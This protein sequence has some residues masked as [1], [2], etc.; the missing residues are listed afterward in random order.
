VNTQRNIILIFIFLTTLVFIGKLYYIQVVDVSFKLS[1]E[2]N[3]FRHITQYPARGIIFD[4][5]NEVIVSNEPTYDLKVYPD[6]LSPFDTAR[7]SELTNISK[8]ELK[9][10]LKSGSRFEAVTLIKQMPKQQYARLQEFLYRYP[11]FYTEQRALR[12]YRRPIA[13]HILGYVSE[14]KQSEIDNDSYYRR[15]D[16]IGKSGVER[17][18]ESYLRG[19]KGVK[20]YLADVHNR[21][22]GSYANGRYD[23]SAVAGKNIILSIDGE[24]QHYGEQLMKNKIG[25][26]VAIEPGS[27]EILAL[28]SSPSYDPGL[29]VGKKLKENYNS[30]ANAPFKPLYN[31]ALKS[32]YPPGSTF[33][34]VNALI[35]FEKGVINPNTVFTVYGYHAG[36]HY[37]NDH[38]FGPVS[39]EKSIQF[40]S[41]AYYCHVFGKILNNPEFESIE[42]AYKDWK[43]M[44]Q[45]MGLGVKLGTDLAYED[46][47]LIF[48]STY[49]DKYYGKGRWNHNTLISLAFGQGELGF[50]PL[51]LANMGAVIANE[52]FYY[53]PHIVKSI[54]DEEINQQYKLK[55]Y[56]AIDSKYYPPVKDALEKVVSGGT[57]RSA[58]VEGLEICGKTGTAQN[59][60]GD[61]HSIFFAFAPKEN[62][63]IVVS[64][65]VENAGYGST[66]AA[67]IASMMI[68]K[69]LTDSI[70]NKWQEKRIMDANLLPKK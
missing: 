43:R 58:Y 13:A 6:Q 37:V 61:D 32:R 62:P 41:N 27:G 52:G 34:P 15:G 11:D 38:I 49:F 21:L 33:K 48:P 17:T 7:F 42:D 4:R 40:S 20:I 14:T 67:P 53:K 64:V 66:W 1:A 51:Q 63:K 47:G 12:V 57:A 5:N 9:Q 65:Y 23:T 69:Y 18:Y 54:E 25:G 31:R 35:G 22:Q 16:F 8:T 55:Y 68:E 3:T 29:F 2:N 50:T 28:I 10:I 30:V 24:L 19:R 36:S 70:T 46:K 45:S 59:P 44:V 39:F 60:H 26:I 56:A